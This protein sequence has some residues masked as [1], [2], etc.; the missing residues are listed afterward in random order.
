M[1]F[2]VA[3]KDVEGVVSDL[4]RLPE[5]LIDKMVGDCL[6]VDF[7]HS[8]GQDSRYE[9]RPP[10]YPQGSTWSDVPAVYDPGCN[11]IVIATK[12]GVKRSVLHEVGHWVDKQMG[13][14]DTEEF[15]DAHDY[16]TSHDGDGDGRIDVTDSYFTN[17]ENG[18]SEA[19]A[20][21]FQRHYGSFADEVL[22]PRKLSDN[23]STKTDQHVQDL[24]KNGLLW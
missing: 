16:D 4:M 22:A 12:F 24:A 7:V 17:E 23:F 20:E 9:G 19:F 21:A 3:T 14:S 5:G 18:K 13:H 6:K 2:G 1:A 15:E 8:I 10:G 11:R